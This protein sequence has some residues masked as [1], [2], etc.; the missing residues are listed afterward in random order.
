MSFQRGVAASVAVAAV[1]YGVT[2]LS[3]SI[4]GFAGLALGLLVAVFSGKNTG[5]ATQAEAAEATRSQWDYI[6][7][8]GGTAG[9][10][11]ANRL[12]K[13][14]K[15][16]V[17]VLE[18][19]EGDYDNTMVRMPAGVLRLFRSKYD[20]NF[21]TQNET[22]TS[23]RSIY[24]CR[25][26][27]L[28][29][30]SSLNVLLYTRGNAHDYDL[31]ETK[32]GCKGWSGCDVLPHFTRTEDDRTGAAAKD[33]KH[34]AVGGEWAVDHVRYQNPLSKAFLKSCEEAGYKANDDFNNWDR[35]QE[36][37]GRFPV[38]QR[39]GARCDSASALLE[40]A[41]ADSGRVV[42]V[43]TGAPVQRVVF[44]GTTA[45]GV[46]FL[47]EG[48][49][50]VARLALGGEVLLT[51]GALHSPQLLMVSGVGPR[52]HLAEHG[53][54]LVADVP[55]VGQNLQDHPAAVV[56]YQ[57]PAAKKGVSVTSKLRI[58]GTAISHP[59]PLLEWLFSKSGVLTSTGCDHGG[60]VHTS[61]AP[62]DSPSPDLQMRFLAARAVTADG[63]GTFVTFKKTTAHPDGF[64]FQC[65]A[66]RPESRGR[67]LLAS[68]DPNE[69]PVVEG[70][71]LTSK[72]DVATIREGLR[73][74][75][76][77]ASQ[78]AFAEYLGEE[79]FP[80][81]DIVTDTQ[82]DKYIADSVHTANALVGTCRMG[83]A[84]DP[85]AAVDQDMRVKGTQGLRVCDSSVMPKL[86]G[87]QTGSSTV[88]IA[89]RASDLILNG[90]L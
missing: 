5:P 41:M 24:L 69:K 2:G 85:E 88:M 30:S 34:H 4:A 27:V 3:V 46:Q 35:S 52:E 81:P 42:R 60:F 36:G 9:C 7:V 28:G 33:K 40:P 29:G 65:I 8:G 25:G 47:A 12:S 58:A 31:W 18:A 67:V 14:G 32:F 44:D 38:S 54:P 50:H 76:T 45:K 66:A 56:S 64:T 17:L 19:G 16:R 82:L 83:A 6:I 39:D 22:A 1:A 79:V 84:S 70:N 21:M 61:A 75:R 71:Y 55:A 43:L 49:P 26:K 59:W 10:L 11:L 57:C 37:F 62:A 73:L 87:G 63:M 74:A 15:K 20:W 13:D 51:G 23:G 48:F 53:I 80:G 72:G 78:A 86:P 89:E 77:L 68:A 90:H